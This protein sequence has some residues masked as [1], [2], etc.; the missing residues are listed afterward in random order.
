MRKSIEF[1]MSGGEVNRYHTM[2]TLQRETVGHHSHATAC[3]VLL[4]NPE[5]SRE[6]LIAALF[7]DLAE[8]Y[9]GDIPS[10][11]KREYGIGDQVAT[12]EKRLIAEAGLSW[13]VLTAGDERLLKIADLAHGALS[14]IREISLGNR[15]M[16]VVFER[17]VSYAADM[18]LAGYERV[19]FDNIM[20]IYNE[21]E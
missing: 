18:G 6:V 14:C 8:Q 12:L 20:E 17:F 2:L 1:I 3:L 15:R 16:R 11:A 19:M 9:T 4:L 5:A 21:C 13:P 7:H 10:P